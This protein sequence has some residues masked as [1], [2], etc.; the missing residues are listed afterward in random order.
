MI[1]A[2]GLT[3]AWQ[4]VLVFDDLRTGEVNRARE[5]RWFASGK[6]VNVALAAH[7]LGASARLLSF[8]GGASGAALAE[9]FEATGADATW[10]TSG[11]PTRVCTTLLNT[12]RK[13]T[14]ELV[15]NS[16]AVSPQELNRY[17]KGFV[18]AAATADVIV[19]SGSLPN[20]TPRSF[21]REL[22]DAAREQAPALAGAS[23][24]AARLVLDIRG[25]ELLETLPFR[26]FLVKPNREELA[27]TVGH[28]LADDAALVA[29]MRGLN[30]Q[31]AEWVLVTSGGQPAWLTGQGQVWRGTPPTGIAV[32]NPIGCGDSV[33]AGVA[34]GLAEGADPQACV[35]LGFGAAAANLER[36]E[37]A[38]FPGERAR[39]LGQQVKFERI[40]G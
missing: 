2:A 16:A 39:E 10:V 19:L 33:A 1:L 7:S 36:M 37:C 38:R 9:D 25:P 13:E 35:A 27:A 30:A 22:L 8:V 11:T 18:A 26:P 29:A 4:Y 17:L 31:G 3:P 5:S 28:S 12:A 14:T 21:Y 34:V 6:G 40:G 24:T 20:G 32:V 15:E 23:A